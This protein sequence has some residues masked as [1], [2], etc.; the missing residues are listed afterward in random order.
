MVLQS[1]ELAGQTRIESE[2]VQIHK[3][4][5]SSIPKV[6][7]NAA[8][9]RTVRLKRATALQLQ[10]FL[11][12]LLLL[13]SVGLE[14]VGKMMPFPYSAVTHKNGHVLYMQYL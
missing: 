5:M 4:L 12:L 7:M 6:S 14:L 11:L 10:L 3:S 9:Q 8:Y 1:C 2:N 13:L